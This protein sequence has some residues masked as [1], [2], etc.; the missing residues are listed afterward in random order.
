MKAGQKMVYKTSSKLLY[1]EISGVGPR[2]GGKTRYRLYSSA[3]INVYF[4]R[5]VS[6]GSHGAASG[7]DIGTGKIHLSTI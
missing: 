2:G 5:G 4:V 6:S 7:D 1:L 3:M